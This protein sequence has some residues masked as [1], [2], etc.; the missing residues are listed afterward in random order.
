MKKEVLP[1]L[2]IGVICGQRIFPVISTP[3]I[4][5]SS[6]IRSTLSRSE[7]RSSFSILESQ[8]KTHSTLCIKFMRLGLTLLI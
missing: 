5:S 7:V 8:A 4:T 2:N 1:T 6:R 3:W